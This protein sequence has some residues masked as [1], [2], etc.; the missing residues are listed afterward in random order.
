MV[1]IR[2]KKVK[3]TQYGYLVESKWDPKKKTSR[4][5]TLKYLGKLDDITLEDLPEKYRNDQKI[6]SFLVSRNPAN[7]REK[8]KLLKK[9]RQETFDYLTNG[10]LESLL[11]I[12]D[13][14]SYSFGI[15]EFYESILK[16]AMYLIGDLWAKK[17]LPVAAEHIASNVAHSLVK[18]LSDKLV[19]PASKQKILICTPPGESHNLGC[20]ILESYL[21]SRGFNVF[22]ISPSVPT[23]SIISFIK[24]NSPDVILVSITLEDNI[25]SGKRLIVKIREKFK[26]PI[27]VGGHALSGK[28]EQGF[29]AIEAQDLS[30]TDLAKMLTTV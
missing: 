3:G 9:L 15:V 11:K 30:M 4:Q 17:Q 5:V 25:P 29:D 23:D 22:N 1:Y 26:T 18:I 6:T 13:T 27:F 7:I 8:E 21:G 10:D 20:N 28:M 12:Y 24:E 19:K 2:S 16:H 14:Y